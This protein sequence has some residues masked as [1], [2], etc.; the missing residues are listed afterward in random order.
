MI[1]TREQLKEM[2]L[3]Q[4]TN[5]LLTEINREHASMLLRFLALN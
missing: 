5:M 4:S 3:A 1:V 2:L